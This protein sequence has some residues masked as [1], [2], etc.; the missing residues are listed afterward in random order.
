[1][2]RTKDVNLS[3]ECLIQNLDTFTTLSCIDDNIKSLWKLYDSDEN[4]N[5][6][7][8]LSEIY[9][10][11]YFNVPKKKSSF[12]F[13]LLDILPAILY[14]KIE[15]ISNNKLIIDRLGFILSDSDFKLN[16]KMKN[17]K[18]KKYLD[19]IEMETANPAYKYYKNISFEINK[20]K[21]LYNSKV[22]F[23][24]L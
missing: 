24:N 17:L 18:I 16:D 2:L 12:E 9:K 8:R 14:I 5:H 1:M 19:S 20:Y 13:L 6:F 15:T 11:F 3:I 10:Y 21:S 23:L 22:K 7:I 4:V